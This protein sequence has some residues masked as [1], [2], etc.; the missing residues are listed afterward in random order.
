MDRM[1]LRMLAL[2]FGSSPPSKRFTCFGEP[3]ID[4]L[5]SS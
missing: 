4:G 3:D 5:V 1:G 2:P